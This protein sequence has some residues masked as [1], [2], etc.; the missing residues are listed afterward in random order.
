MKWLYITLVMVGAMLLYRSVVKNQ[1]ISTLAPADYRSKWLILNGFL[2]FFIVGYSGYALIHLFEVDV[3][4]EWLVVSI[5][6]G[7]A[8]FVYVITKMTD[9]SFKELSDLNDNLEL[10]VEQRTTELAMLN[11]QLLESQ[12]EVE[13]RSNFLTTILNSLSHPFYVIDV[14]KHKILLAND[15][16]GFDLDAPDITCHTMAHGIN[17]PCDDRSHPCALKEIEK[18]GEPV[19]LEHIHKAK[20]GDERYVE[21]HGYPIYDQEGELAQVIEYTIDVTGKK[22][23]EIQLVAAKKEA[24]KA[25]QIKSEFLANMSHEVRTPMSAILGMTRLVLETELN[26]TQKFYLNTVNDSSEM[27]LRIVNDILDYSRLESGALELDPRPFRLR[28]LVDSAIRMMQSKAE[29]KGLSLVAD[30]IDIGSI[31][32]VR[33]DDLRLRQ[34]LMNIIDNSIKFTG[35][36]GI[37]LGVKVAE[38]S[39]DNLLLNFWVIDSG[40]GI[41]EAAQQ[42][43]FENFKQADSSI[44]RG[45]GGTG[46]GLSI[47]QKLVTLMD[48]KIWLESLE[49][50]GTTV[51][52][53][54][55]VEIYT[56]EELIPPALTTPHTPFSATILLVDDVAAN[57]DLV[58]I[59]LEQR[60]FAVLEASSGFAALELLINNEVDGILL[61]IEMPELDGYQVMTAIRDAETGKFSEDSLV[62]DQVLSQ[63]VETLKNSYVPVIAITA[64]AME[65]DQHKSFSAGMDGYLSKPFNPDEMAALLHQILPKKQNRIVPLH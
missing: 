2:I 11:N 51:Y 12:R 15:A 19:V 21:I 52:F 49:G 37:K 41:P 43:I 42:T 64:R 28:E 22:M 30:T 5:L 16:T 40:I 61:D 60:G 1:K 62:P 50:S 9:Q 3:P 17:I 33:G 10:K 45:Y 46:L 48:G 65:N 58:R 14:K 39:A 57:R 29:D 38:K 53:S 7:G 47:C 26:E 36:G 63:L 34:V 20:D 13:Q 56:K 44:S 32:M 24:E 27:L 31:D 6:F 4:L 18:S 54:T 55:R 8:L 35:E 23:T 25:S 59:L